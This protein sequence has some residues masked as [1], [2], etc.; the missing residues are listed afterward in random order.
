M[1]YKTIVNIPDQHIVA[2]QNTR[3]FKALGNYLLENT[4][5]YVVNG[6]DM[7]E[8]KSLYGVTGK[9]SWNTKE[10]LVQEVETDIETGREAYTEMWRPLKEHNKTLRKRKKKCIKLPESHFCWGNHD[11]RIRHYVNLNFLFFTERWETN[12]PL[13]DVLQQKEFWDHEYD[14]QV[15]VEIEGILFSH[16]YSSGTA[17][18]ST[19]ET[20]LKLAAQSAV[21]FHSHKAEFTSSQTATGR[22]T[23]ILQ[24]GWF[25]DPD[26]NTPDWVGP[27]GGRNWWN[28]ITILHGVD[29]SGRFDPEFM[30]TER[31]IREYL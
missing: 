3:R 6:G 16:N 2:G 5:D 23:F 12:D 9:K 8:A 1:K 19:N 22:P 21:G 18:A 28:G 25:S 30:S 10:E 26:D 14:Y 13:A 20:I 15:P 7:F 29:G 4:P 24:S 11:E 31:L 17:T 27:Q